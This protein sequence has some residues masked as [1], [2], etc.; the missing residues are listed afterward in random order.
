MN[1]AGALIEHFLEGID[2]IRHWYIIPNEK[3]KKKS[4]LLSFTYTKALTELGALV[5]SRKI[6]IKANF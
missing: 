1:L 2:P 3:T 5:S 4:S 6:S